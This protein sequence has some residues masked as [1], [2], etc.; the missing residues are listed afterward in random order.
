MALS[1][2]YHASVAALHALGFAEKGGEVVKIL[3]LPI[4]EGVVV[5]HGAA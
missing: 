1:S 2:V 5:T 3:L 4:V